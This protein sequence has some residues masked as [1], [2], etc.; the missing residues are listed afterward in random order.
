MAFPLKLNILVAI[1]AGV[2]AGIALEKT[3]PR[4]P[5]PAGRAAR[6]EHP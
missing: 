4:T 2:G 3:A 6:E 5:L 1:A